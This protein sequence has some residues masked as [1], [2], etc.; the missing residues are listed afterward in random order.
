MNTTKVSNF[1]LPGALLLGSVAL[2]DYPLTATSSLTALALAGIFRAAQGSQDKFKMRE[3]AF[4]A[5]IGIAP[6]SLYRLWNGSGWDRLGYAGNAVVSS[7]F[8]YGYA[9]SFSEMRDISDRLVLLPAIAF[10]VYKAELL[11]PQFALIGLGLTNWLAGSSGKEA[12]RFLAKGVALAALI[13]TL[14]TLYS[15]FQSSTLD[16]Q[17]LYAGGAAIHAARLFL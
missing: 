1:L 14:H 11:P 12:H 10:G 16:N 6:L 9:R 17:L 5:L 13:P 3:I 7:F 2:R 8:L 15:T 4:S